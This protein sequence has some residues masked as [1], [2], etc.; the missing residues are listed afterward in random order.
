VGVG[1]DADLLKLGDGLAG[2]DVE[3]GDGS[4]SS[5]KKLMRQARSS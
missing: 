4:I 3:L 2:E 5:P 1:V